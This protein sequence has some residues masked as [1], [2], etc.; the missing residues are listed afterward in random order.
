MLKIY[1]EC[2]LDGGLN[3]DNEY[4]SDYVEEISGLFD[5]FEHI[6]ENKYLLDLLEYGPCGSSGDRLY[7]LVPTLLDYCKDYHAKATFLALIDTDRFK[8]LPTRCTAEQDIE[9][10]KYKIKEERSSKY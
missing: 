9:Y 4:T 3:L 5:T 8:Q 10:L 2:A 6:N 7:G 1:E